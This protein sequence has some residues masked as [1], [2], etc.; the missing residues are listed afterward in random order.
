MNKLLELQ[1]HNLI[2]LFIY[3]TIS[4]LPVFFKKIKYCILS[5]KG[6]KILYNVITVIVGVLYITSIL[7]VLYFK[8]VD[9]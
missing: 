7:R 9:N 1:K 4:W 5:N 2:L 8:C 6:L 3:L